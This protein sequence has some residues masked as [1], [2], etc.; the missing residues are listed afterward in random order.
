MNPN[1]KSGKPQKPTKMSI[2]EEVAMELRQ[3][4]GMLTLE[5]RKRLAASKGAPAEGGIADEEAAESPTEEAG[6]QPEQY[7]MGQDTDHLLAEVDQG[8]KAPGDA[9]LRDAPASESPGKRFQKRK[10]GSPVKHQ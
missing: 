2:G 10:M 1:L 4:L 5:H 7:D 8:K 6:E 3:H 9:S